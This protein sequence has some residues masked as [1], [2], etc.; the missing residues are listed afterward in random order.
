MFASLLRPVRGALRVVLAHDAPSQ[1]AAGFA[2]GMV[3][4]LVPKGNLIA[5]SLLVLLFSLRV[6]SGMGIVAALV[7]SWIGPALDPFS[8]KLG[9]YVLSAPSLQATYATLINLPLGPWFELDNSVVTGSL[10]SGLYFMYPVYW[11][12]FVFCR[13]YQSR[14]RDSD[15]TQRFGTDEQPGRRAA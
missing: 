14:L 7:F 12:T 11:V 8:D 3:L 2:L 4:G 9:V 6:N 5:V 15:A 13:R 10:L 1:L